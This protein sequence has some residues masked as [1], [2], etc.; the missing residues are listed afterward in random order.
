[1]NKTIVTVIFIVLVISVQEVNAQPLSEIK[2]ER[3][4]YSFGKIKEEGGPATFNFRFTN[5]GTIPLI[6]QGVEASCGCTTPEWSSEPIL[7]GKGG[8]IKVSYNPEMRPG[9][10]AKS[11]TV[12]ANVPKSS[13][14]LTISGEVIPRALGMVDLYPVD[15]GKIRLASAELSF[16]RIKNNEVKTD[17][18]QLFN[19][20][21]SPVT[22]NFKII[23]PHISIKTIPS[24]IPPQS[25]GFFLITLDAPKKQEYGYVTN[26]IYLSFNGEEKFKDAIK[27]SATIEEDFSKFSDMEL[28]NAPHIEYNSRTFDFG[29]IPEGKRVAYTFL[30]RNTGKKE[31]IIRSVTASCSCTTGQPASNNI[32]AGGSTE[33]KVSFDSEGKVGMQNKIITVI[34]NDPGHSTTILRVTGN[35]KK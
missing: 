12:N 27:V 5:T 16:V 8:F 23:P 2:F 9:A 35:V 25:K 15:F 22:V 17:T 13:R 10:F 11:I 3:M 7:P 33:M 24:V 31:L 18:L 28:A 30:I 4:D 20:G 19:P 6:I 26:R 21:N 34:S 14:V 32:P 1:M 29:E